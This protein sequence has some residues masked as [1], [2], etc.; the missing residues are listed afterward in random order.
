MGRKRGFHQ[1][2]PADDNAATVDEDSLDEDNQ[3]Q[4]K[5]ARYTEGGEVYGHQL[6]SAT[7]SFSDVIIISDSSGSP[8]SWQEYDSTVSSEDVL[9]ESSGNVNAGST[10]D[11]PPTWNPGVSV[12]IRTSLTDCK[13][14]TQSLPTQSNVDPQTSAS[15][16]VD[17]VAV[18]IKTPKTDSPEQSLDG[19]EIGRSAATKDHSEEPVDTKPRSEKRLLQP[20][21]KHKKKRERKLERE[22][23][24]EPGL[25]EEEGK[26]ETKRSIK[27]AKILAQLPSSFGIP[28]RQKEAEEIIKGLPEASKD[29]MPRDLADIAF[30]FTKMGRTFKLPQKLH[31]DLPVVSLGKLSFRNPLHS[32]VAA[33]LKENQSILEIMD[34]KLLV[35]AF[36]EYLR[37]LYGHLPDRL[38][39][40]VCSNKQIVGPKAENGCLRLLDEAKKEVLRRTELDKAH[41]QKQM[42][43]A[44]ATGAELRKTQLQVAEANK[45]RKVAREA[46][47]K[48]RKAAKEARGAENRNAPKESQKYSSS[49][50]LESGTPRFDALKEMPT[51]SGIESYE[52]AQKSQNPEPYSMGRLL[53]AKR[54]QTQVMNSATTGITPATMEESS[55]ERQ[56]MGNQEPNSETM[57]GILRISDQGD[58]EQ[59]PGNSHL[60]DLELI[61][62]YHPSRDGSSIVHYCLICAQ[63]DHEISQCPSLTC[64]NCHLFGVHFTE[65]CPRRQRC[66]KCHERGHKKSDCPEKLAAT[67]DESLRCDICSS[68]KHLESACHFLWRSFKPSMLKTTKFVADIPIHCYTCGAGGHFGSECGIRHSPLNTEGYSWSISNWKR[69]VDP[70]SLSRALSAGKDFSL[71][72]STKGKKSFNIRGSARNGNIVPMEDDENIPFIREKVTKPTRPLPRG[73]QHIKFDQT[74]H[75]DNDY[76]PQHHLGSPLA[77]PRYQQPQNARP[78]P[79]Q[80]AYAEDRHEFSYRPRDDSARYMRERS[81]SPPPRFHEERY[82]PR[83]GDN[84]YRMDESF[85]SYRPYDRGISSSNMPTRAQEGRGNQN[86]G[87]TRGV[88]AQGGPRGTGAPRGKRQRNRKG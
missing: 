74:R 81:F 10:N 13:L 80:K 37:L 23:K 47:T 42:Q 19:D 59:N 73:T 48:A 51:N 27:R 11:P 25:P 65:G 33:F 41:H 28:S 82:P 17:T 26:I 54:A 71:P 31:K 55:D 9:T 66:T 29:L 22:T 53:G 18:F 38:L 78:A 60:N 83:P 63:T 40:I 5:R 2:S 39:S 68:I 44:E 12:A 52:M 1:L 8:D 75:L 64:A 21:Q 4:E 85:D 67:A 88:T 77:D 79:Q 57:S 69:Y 50:Q 30:N 62:R 14:Q 24:G 32:F 15:Q 87:P 43:Q 56:L 6:N 70:Q 58:A 49:K 84:Y 34:Y 61:R 7:E 72:P 3:P 46:D 35:I 36:Q 20:L 45:T 16:E 86:Q 76:V